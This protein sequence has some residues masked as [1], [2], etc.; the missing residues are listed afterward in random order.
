MQKNLYLPCICPIFFQDHKVPSDWQEICV[1]FFHTSFLEP[2]FLHETLNIFTH[3]KIKNLWKLFHIKTFM[4]TILFTLDFYFYCFFRPHHVLPHLSQP[5]HHLPIGYHH[6][7]QNW[8]AVLSQDTNLFLA[9]DESAKSL[10]H[11]D[12]NSQILNTYIYIHTSGIS[13]YQKSTYHF[14]L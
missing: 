3:T 7:H 12:T 4:Q 14:C 8:K 11:K 2:L 6:E 9:L 10:G 13:E 5:W 1:Y